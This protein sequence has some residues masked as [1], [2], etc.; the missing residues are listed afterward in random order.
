MFKRKS[1]LIPG[2]FAASCAAAII[3]AAAGCQQTGLKSIQPGSLRGVPALKFSYSFEP[4][5][6][7]PVETEA[8]APGE[9][10]VPAVQADFDQNRPEEI[11]DKT[12]PSPDKQRILVVYHHA[13]DR[14]TEFRLDMYGADGKLLRKISPDA[15]AISL[16]DAITWSPDNTTAAFIA[17]AR[18]QVK[19]PAANAATAPADAP[20]PPDVET[21]E[22]T[23]ANSDANSAANTNTNVNAATPAPPVP[24][25]A[26]IKLFSNEQVY[27]VNKDGAD[28]KCI[29]QKDTLIYFYLSWSP[30]STMLATLATTPIEWQYGELN[31]KAR[32]EE[33]I[34][35]GRPHLIEKI[36]RERLL[37]D[38]PSA[39][40]PVWSPDSSKVACAFD[41]DVKI[42][43][44]GETPTYA[45]IPLRVPLLTS[46]QRYDQNLR[47]QEKGTNTN[48]NAANNA[49]V[50]NP[51]PP[52]QGVQ[53]MPNEADLVSFNPI[54]ELRWTEEKGIYVQTGYIKQMLDSR[55]SS[56]SYM[57]W[58]KINLS[59][60]APAAGAPK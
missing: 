57:R 15:M 58:H 34:P 19:T 32:G 42:Y 13:G 35:S 10:R 33:F 60:Q 30:D 39:V 55:F 11:L 37:D 43:D 7:P 49:P 17:V 23:A 38:N 4:D 56:R 5:A 59:S 6:L 40:H 22:N 1:I 51:T 3:I 12:A 2:V 54:V 20:T 16:P 26:P 44:A 27:T 28:L 8:P 52:N 29:S 47:E 36:G 46:S 25:S 45:A 18:E 48:A 9:E 21:N 31:S 24:A 50:P 53:V 41:K 14:E